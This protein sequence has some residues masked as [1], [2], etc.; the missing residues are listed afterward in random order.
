[1]KLSERSPVMRGAPLCQPRSNAKKSTRAE[2]RGALGVLNEVSNDAAARA[3]RNIRRAAKSAM[4]TLQ[5]GDLSIGVR[6]ERN[7]HL[8]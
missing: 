1:M 4:D 7:L 5:V 3:P 6:A 2:S 8:R